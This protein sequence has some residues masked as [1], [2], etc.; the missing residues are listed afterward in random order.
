MYSRLGCEVNARWAT[1]LVWGGF[2]GKTI[3]AAPFI[4]VE[5]LCSIPALHKSRIGKNLYGGKSGLAKTAI[6]HHPLVLNN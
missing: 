4:V 5:I 6:P 3:P 1:G 2:R